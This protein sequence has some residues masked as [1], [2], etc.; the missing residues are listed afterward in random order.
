MIKY[1]VE[2]TADGTP[3]TPILQLPTPLPVTPQAVAEVLGVLLHQ[4][5]SRHQ[6]PHQEASVGWPCPPSSARA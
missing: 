3:T 1:A 5:S 2:D 6:A 4:L